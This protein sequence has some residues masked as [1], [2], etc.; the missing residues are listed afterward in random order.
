[1][2]IL[3]YLQYTVVVAFGAPITVVEIIGFVTGALCVWGVARQRLWSWPVGIANNAAF[4][5]LFLGTGLYGNAV[6]QLI[7]AGLAIYGWINWLRGRA[8][9]STSNDLPVTAASPRGIAFMAGAVLLGT[10]VGALVLSASTDSTAAI[11][12]AFILVGSLGATFWQAR[13][14]IQ[15]WW[16]W[17]TIDVVSIPL[18]ISRGLLLT[19]LLYVIFLALCV[20]GLVDWQ[21][22]RQASR[23]QVAVPA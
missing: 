17:I 21:R 11:P 5:I 16:V 1:M 6:L 18:Y 14:T 2:S 20:Y 10:A 12:D 23:E 8:D 4:L 3:D 19:G 7:F 22:K 15:H 9:S 13:K